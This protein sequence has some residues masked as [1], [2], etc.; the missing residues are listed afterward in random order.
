MFG[1][2]T[3]VEWE[4]DCGYKGDDSLRNFVF[5]LRNPRSAAEIR[6]EEGAEGK[7]NR[8]PFCLLCNI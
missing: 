8:L 4:Y 5:T 2:F 7:G 6:T 1:G 3:P